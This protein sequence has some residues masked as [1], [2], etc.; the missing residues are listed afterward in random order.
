MIFHKSLRKHKAFFIPAIG[1]TITL[2]VVGILLIS[3][4]NAI[5][6]EDFE[7]PTMTWNSPKKV[8]DYFVSNLHMTPEDLKQQEGR[9]KISFYVTEGTTL[10]AII[11]NLTYY[12]L[13][14]TEKA[15]QY[16]LENTQD[17]TETKE[18]A[19]K[20]GTAGTIDIN[21]YYTISEN[22]TAWELAEQLLNNPHFI[23]SGVNYGYMFMP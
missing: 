8:E 17:K 14:R 1:V 6:Q 2:L 3:K 21:A 15:L 12:G 7:A 18:G 16:A 13:A 23:G 20:V 22:M 10:Q 11:S 4:T 9:T 19:I 5:P